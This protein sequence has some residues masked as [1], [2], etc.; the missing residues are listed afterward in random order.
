[1]GAKDQRKVAKLIKR[2]RHLGLIP[3]MG[4]WK[5]EDHGFFHDKTLEDE[6]KRDWEI[7]LEKRGLWPLADETEVFKRYYGLDEM[8]DHVAGGVDSKKRAELEELLRG[9][10]DEKMKTHDS[11]EGAES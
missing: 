9:N 6:E 7:E 11:S 10:L 3:H 8:I 4:Q 1:L 5:F 2:A